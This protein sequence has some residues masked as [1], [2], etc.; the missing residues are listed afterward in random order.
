MICDGCWIC[1]DAKILSDV[2]IEAGSIVALG[3]IVNKS[4][5]SNSLVGGVPAKHL[6]ALP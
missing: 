5:P 1:G 4:I 6:R 3:S 2:E